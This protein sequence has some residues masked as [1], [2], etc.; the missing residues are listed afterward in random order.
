MRPRVRHGGAVALP[1]STDAPAEQRF[2][3]AKRRA[4]ARQSV[5]RTPMMPRFAP[6]IAIILVALLWPLPA[7][8]GPPSHVSDELLVRFR[9][10]T[11]P[12]YRAALHA[13][14]GA[15][16]VRTFA[17]VRDLHLMKLPRGRST[18]QAI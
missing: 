9:P 4:R 12:A 17:T 16:P 15:S 7:I 5:R 8:A 1:R 3:A 11:T 18:A 10:G 13:A 6:F 2:R 14:A